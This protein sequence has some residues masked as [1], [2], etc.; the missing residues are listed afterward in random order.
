MPPQPQG[1]KVHFSDFQVQGL[2]AASECCSAGRL[3][4]SL[5]IAPNTKHEEFDGARKA[6]PP[7]R[8]PGA[9]QGPGSSIPS[10]S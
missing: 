2:E 9:L 1:Y 8:L 6:N 10:L 3:V 7:Q 5:K 4:D